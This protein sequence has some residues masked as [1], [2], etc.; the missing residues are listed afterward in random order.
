MPAYD[1][2]DPRGKEQ[3]YELIRK[4]QSELRLAKRDA[5][6]FERMSFILS[7]DYSGPAWDEAKEQATLEFKN[8]NG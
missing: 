4:L 8:A 6:I 1:P 2:P 5:W 7:E 3:D